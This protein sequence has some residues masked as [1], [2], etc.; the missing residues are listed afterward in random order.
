VGGNTFAFYP[1]TVSFVFYSFN[2]PADFDFCTT[3][4]MMQ[5]TRTSPMRRALFATGRHFFHGVA[6]LEESPPDITRL[7]DVK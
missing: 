5:Y 6:K 4:P 1:L 7:P 3:L 2:E